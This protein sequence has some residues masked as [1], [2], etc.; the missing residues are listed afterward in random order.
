MSTSGKG[1]QVPYTTIT[2]HAISRA[3]LAPSIYCQLDEAQA[4]EEEPTQDEETELEMRELRIIPPT[5]DSCESCVDLFAS[6]SYFLYFSPVEPIFEALSR[7]ASMNPDPDSEDGS[8]FNDAYV[9]ADETTQIGNFEVFNGTEEE[10]LSEV[11]RVRN[12]PKNA[13]YAPY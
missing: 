4:L 11:G 8:E 12:D 10:E 2:L 7:C 13:R 5:A 9:D 6:H 1:F 3:D